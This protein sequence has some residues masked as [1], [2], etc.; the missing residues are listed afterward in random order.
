MQEDIKVR[1]TNPNHLLFD[2]LG[3]VIGIK[4]YRGETKVL[5]SFEN[6]E[7]VFD[8]KDVKKD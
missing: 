3:T 2:A 8:I 1:V 7:Q 5:V 4:M 6:F